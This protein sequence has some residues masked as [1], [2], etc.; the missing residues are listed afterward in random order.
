MENLFLTVSEAQNGQPQIHISFKENDVTIFLRDDEDLI[1]FNTE[2]K[3]ETKA[4]FQLRER[5]NTSDRTKINKED[6]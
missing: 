4:Y 6:E 5:N 3:R 2:L 1:E